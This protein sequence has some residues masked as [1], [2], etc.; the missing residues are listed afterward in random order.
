M[1]PVA[2]H[3][4][5]AIA[6]AIQIALA[7]LDIAIPGSALTITG[8][9]L[10]VPL[11]LAV[12]G[13]EREV[14]ITGTV[15]VAVAVGSTFWNDST[16]TGQ[17]IYRIGFFIVF[18]ALAVV[19]ARARE[20]ATAL[21]G[22]NQRLAT[23]LRGTQ[24]RLDGI[25]GSLGEAVTVHDERGK[26]I[27][28]ND[29]AVTLLGSPDVDDVLAAEPGELAQRFQITREDGSPV[30]VDDLPGRRLVA[31]EEAPSLL[32][33]S[34]RRD[35]GEALWL[36]TKATLYTDP[37]GERLAIN[38]IEDVT[39]AKEAELRQ[40][41]LAEAGQLLASSLDYEQTLERVARMIVPGLADWCGIEM[42][43][44]QGGS[45]QVAVA[46][47]DPAKVQMAHDLRRRYPPDPDAPGGLPAILRGGPAE[48]Y[49][50]I[51]D[52][53]IEQA[54]RDEEHLALIRALGM[55][56]AMAVPMR[57]GDETLGAITLVSAESGRRFDA[58]D[59]AF[60]EDLALR[61]ATAVQNARLYAA[62][63]RVA[64][65]LQAS[66]LPERLPPLDGWE[67]S[68]AYQAGER[69]ADVGGDFYDILA[70]EGGHLI[71]LGD[72]TGKGVEAAALTSLVRHSASMAARFDPAPARVLSLVNKVLREQPRL[73][74]VTAVCALVSSAVD[75]AT[76]TVASA[77]HPLPLR[78]GPGEAPAALGEHGVLLGVEGADDWAETVVEIGPGQ[79]VLFYTDGVTETP[80][81]GGRFGDA[82]LR[83]VMAHAGEK[84]EQLLDE[85]ARAL[86]EFQSGA[87]LDDRAL[88]AL[89]FVGVRR[90]GSGTSGGAIAAR[91]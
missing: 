18:A 43:D 9:V 5:L 40:R 88:L 86:R 28:V 14:A 52:E 68:A 10:L 34:V 71:L 50:E 29:A 82:R 79:T 26:T 33:R 46:H 54:A 58:D 76:L 83:E 56:S 55:R 84:P 8:T 2:A 24:A 31:G 7:A 27:Y 91:R 57:I 49:S 73:S 44:E 65:T 47:V 60:A 59:L 85:I 87:V 35:T 90:A 20:R 81:D 19:A 72:V 70:V 6:L 21:A 16:G 1:G 45:H 69:G 48:L 67:A 23:E 64:H 66:L 77:G 53:L 36:L 15:A 75:R 11:V 62:Q 78:R 41:F 22:A 42:V 38:I 37:G 51:P 80:G 4:R 30:Q 74:L 17:T 63:E 25:L 3:R 39:E 12:I 89:R 32:T 13:Q 61:A